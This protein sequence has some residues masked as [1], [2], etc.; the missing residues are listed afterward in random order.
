MHSPVSASQSPRLEQTEFSASFPAEVEIVVATEVLPAP[1]E[2]VKQPLDVH[3]EV[4]V[5]RVAEFPEVNASENWISKDFFFPV[6]A[7]LETS[8]TL[9]LGMAASG[10]ASSA[11]L[12]VI[13]VHVATLIA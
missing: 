4:P 8:T 13:W 12:I 1:F 3:A 6:E 5:V 9:I 10:S 2:I 11:S 7:P